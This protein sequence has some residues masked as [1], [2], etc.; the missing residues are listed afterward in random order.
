MASNPVVRYVGITS[1]ILVIAATWVGMMWGGGKFAPE[2]HAT[3]VATVTEPARAVGDGTSVATVQYPNR[4]G[5]T[6]T[7]TLETAAPVGETLVVEVTDAGLRS[8][9]GTLETLLGALVG[10]ALGAGLA[11]AIGVWATRTA[12][13]Y[14]YIRTPQRRTVHS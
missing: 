14:S 8:P 13:R 7:T 3:V 10:G 11:L 4:D 12:T 1:W 5:A 2:A 6:V 9:Q